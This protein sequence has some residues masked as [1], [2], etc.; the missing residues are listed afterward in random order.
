M[1]GV[2]FLSKPYLPDAVIGAI[3]RVAV[4]EQPN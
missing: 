2:V 3:R 4:P 1:N